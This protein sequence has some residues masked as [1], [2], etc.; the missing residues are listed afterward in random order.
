MHIVHCDSDG[1]AE[2]KGSSSLT[3]TAMETMMG[4]IAVPESEIRRWRR[5]FDANATV[6][7]NGEKCVPVT[8]LSVMQ[9]D[10]TVFQV[11]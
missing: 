4:A 5:N 11:S 7:I 10:P 6:V 1:G 9:I 3:S 2:P 8:A